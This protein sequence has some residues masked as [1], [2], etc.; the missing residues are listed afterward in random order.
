MWGRTQFIFILSYT[1]NLGLFYGEDITYG[2]LI[3]LNEK[4]NVIEYGFI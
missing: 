4:E 3:L 1:I 2:G